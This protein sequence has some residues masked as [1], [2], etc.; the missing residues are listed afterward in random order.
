MTPPSP[1][2][3][4]FLPY[5]L[6]IG[7]DTIIDFVGIACSSSRNSIFSTLAGNL[8]EPGRSVG[9]G[10][11][12][13]VGSGSIV[14]SAHSGYIEVL[15]VRGVFVMDA[16]FG[17]GVREIAASGFYEQVGVVYL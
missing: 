3:R 1:Q 13:Q 10:V 16:T 5:S 2:L 11:G 12:R 6:N 17:A 8:N 9:A 7:I 4:P 15:H 14:G